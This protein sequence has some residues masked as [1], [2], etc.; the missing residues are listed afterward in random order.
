ML[1]DRPLLI[2]GVPFQTGDW[3]EIRS[4]YD[5]ALVGR[6]ARASAVDVR[7]A[8]QA[9]GSAFA[10]G[11]LPL[12]RRIAVLERAG[13]LVAQR[14]DE[15]SRLLVR[16]A[17]KPLRQARTEVA[18]TVETL[19]FSAA[20]ARTQG[21]ELIPLDAVAAGEGRLG[22]VLRVPLG[23]VA[24]ITPF[25]FP[26]N[27]VAHKLGPGLAAGNAI[28]LKPAPQAPLSGFALAEILLEAGLPAG[29]LHVV[30]GG[31][32]VGAELVAA[33]QVAAVTFTGS[34]AVGWGIRQAAPRKR[35]CLEL[36]S[37]APLLID[38]TGDWEDAADRS[39]LAAFGQ[40]GQSC[41]SL[42]RVLVDARVADAFVE[43]L[44]ERTRSLAV[45]D[46]AL[47]ATEVGPLIDAGQ[48]DRVKRW[49]DA[50]LAAGARCVCGGEVNA[51]GTLQPTVLADVPVDAE[52]W[53]AEVFGPVVGVR[54]V[55]SFAE[56]IALAN[57]ADFGLQAG[58]Y[59]R[60]TDRALA[61]ARELQFGGVLINDV[62]T[63]RYEH[64]PYG[65]GKDSGNTREGPLA[66]LRELTEERFVALG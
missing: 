42:Q 51:D 9:A 36:G 18:R 26:L 50:A 1:P 57:D 12:W 40:A 39:A 33:E 19:R 45:G 52:V 20:A 49:I 23:V 13:E 62:P 48:R 43:R 65:G 61:A 21:G 30:A 27:L 34:T 55:H 64:Q 16:E 29:W 44:A 2:D 11:E 38:E 28:V 22:L 35:V 4:P 59:T 6:V 37:T 53:R 47:E 31:A 15:L 24:A 17:G 63:T 8:V 10:A 54:S 32:D 46:P 3:D 14:G 5:G 41:V 66:A 7:L 56:A 60:L 58:V 25:N